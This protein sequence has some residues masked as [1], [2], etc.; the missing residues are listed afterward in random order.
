MEIDIQEKRYEHYEEKRQEKIFKA[1]ER[2]KDMIANPDN[3][4]TKV[5]Y[6]KTKIFLIIFRKK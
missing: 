2:R 1:I 3:I 4:F 6:R 5:N